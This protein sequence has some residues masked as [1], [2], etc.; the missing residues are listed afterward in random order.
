[1][2]LGVLEAN[3]TAHVP[4]TVL[5]DQQAA[6]S[7]DQTGRL[8]HGTGKNA[9]I[10]LSPQP[11]EDPNDPLNWSSA[12][13]H[14]VLAVIF[15]GVIIVGVIPGPLLN[16]GIVQISADL[17]RSPTDVAKLSGYCLLA[18]GAMGPFASALGRKYGKRPMYVFSSLIGTI[19]VIV[20]EVATGYNVL[21][22]GRILQGIGIA[23]YESLAVSSIG[24]IFFVHERGP[25]VA[26]VIFL[27]AAISN[28]ISIIAG[29][30]TEYLGW[31]YNFHIYIPFAALQLIA[32]VLYCPETM[33][34]RKAI[35]ETDTAGSEE[36]LEKL[37]KIESAAAHHVERH[38]HRV[39]ADLEKTMTSASHASV[40]SIPPKKTWFQELA[41]YNGTFVDDSVWKMAIA[42]VAILLN[43]GA[44][45]QVLMT[46]VIIAWYVAVAILSGVVFASP[47]YLLSSASV[48]YM[49]V[50]PFIGGL[51]GAIFSLVISEPL[52]KSMTRRNKGVYEPEFALLPISLGGVCSVA[53]L[54]GWG[55]AVSEF[56]SVYLVCF[57]WAIILFGMTVIASFATQWAL[58]AYRQNSTELFIMNMVFKNFFF[59]GLTNYVIDWYATTGAI[60]MAGI[61]AGITGFL[62]LLAIPMYVFGKKYRYFWHK[63]NA[64]KWLHLETDHSGAEGG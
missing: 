42:S 53:G 2:G 33:Y 62:C 10:V 48:G 61:M 57:I 46:G 20:S 45:Y 11:S 1:M 30:I 34:R 41:V 44:T 22:A 8:K 26:V 64:L 37:A 21:L 52:V 32:V 56:K 9:N 47:P 19:G 25:R 3:T 40:D 27:L 60:D 18:T 7:E 38:D 29:V 58:D 31:K 5:L 4:G 28:G 63:H 35:Y 16:A 12:K 17:Q 43:V 24:D 51:I 59:Y 36:N 49:S 15:F 23:A 6:H 50:G 13:K 54:V 55:Y 39:G 14:I